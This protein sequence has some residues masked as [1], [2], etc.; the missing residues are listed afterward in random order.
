MPPKVRECRG[1]SGLRLMI[2]IHTFLYRHK[3]V[4]LKTVTLL[5]LSEQVGFVVSFEM[6]D[7]RVGGRECRK[8]Q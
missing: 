1:A 7:G 5:T 8:V 2:I 6:N 3:V 4:T